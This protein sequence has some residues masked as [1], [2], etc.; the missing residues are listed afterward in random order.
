VY[1]AMRTA[2]ADAVWVMQGWIFTNN[3]K[4][5]QPTQ[6]KSLLGA[7]PDDRMILLDLACE[8]R[9]V[10]NKTEAF[11]GKPWIWNVI[12]DYGDVVSLHGGLPQI[13]ASLHEATTSAKR[14]RLVGIGFVNEGLGAN[15]VINDFM[16]EMAWQTKLP[17]IE[18]WVRGHVEGRYG[19]CPGAAGDAWRLL[20]ETVYRT[21][22]DAGGPICT[23]PS[24]VGMASDRVGTNRYDNA[25]LA[26]A[27]KRLLDC[28]DQLGD[29]DTYRFDLVHVGRQVLANLALEVRREAAVAYGLR[30]R[31]ALA[32]ASARFL[33]LI[34]DTDELLATRQELLLGRWLADAKR[35]ATNDEERRLYEQNARTIIT[36]WGARENSEVHD[37]ANKQWSGMLIGFYL[38]R[39]ERFFQQADS[40]LAGGKP[41]DIEAFHR[42]LCDWELQWTRQAEPYTAVPRGDA[43]AIS[44]RLWCRYGS[45]FGGMPGI[46]WNSISAE[47]ITP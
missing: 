24:W 28:A 17:V 41:L 2:D 35:W 13:A 36:L 34:R 47:P 21:P 44:R 39:W 33:Q 5:W 30:D 27:W 25:K 40:A 26:Q 9:P 6:A 4:F 12:Q 1:E 19:S 20:S 18:D 38:P 42:T 16:G 11:Y 45:C 7:V 8:N 23:R 46:A 43:V 22:A 37:Y 10:W 3:P 29:V 32:D 14:G 15:P 31:R